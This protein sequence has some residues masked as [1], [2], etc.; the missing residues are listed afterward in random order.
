VI[1]K[2]LTKAH[3]LASCHLVLFQAPLTG[4]L[5]APNDRKITRRHS[6]HKSTRSVEDKGER[7]FI[8]G[9]RWRLPR[10][11]TRAEIDDRITRL[12]ELW[13]DHEQFTLAQVL[14]APELMCGLPEQLLADN[15]Q[16]F[17]RRS[18]GIG[19]ASAASQAESSDR[20]W[21]PFGS[22]GRKGEILAHQGA[23][24]WSP[25]ALWIA[26]QIKLG[27]RPLPLPP[28][29]E[30][31][32]SLT[33]EG[34]VDYRFEPLAHRLAGPP[35][36]RLSSTDQLTWQDALQL[37]NR[38]TGA[39]PSVAWSLPAHHMEEAARAQEQI[40]RKAIVTAAHVRSQQ[41]PEKLPLIPGSFHEALREYRKKRTADFT[42]GG[43]FDG[44]GHHML[45]L[46]ENFENRQP[47]VPLAMLDFSRCQA[48]YDFWR[49]RPVNLRTNQ[50]LSLKHCSS[51]I[52]ELTRFFK[53]LHT[54]SQFAWRWPSDFDL[55]D[56]KVKRLPSDRRSIQ[57]I[58]L[59]TFA[60][61]HLAL[62]YKHA[63]PAQ[64][65][66]LVWCLNC[67]H[68]AAEMGRVEWEDLFLSQP[69]PW[70]SEGLKI[71]SS[72][73]DSWCGLLRPKT[74]VVGWWWLWPETVHLV[75][76]WKSHLEQRLR[77]AVNPSER[78]LLTDKGMPLY[79]DTSRNA[80]SSFQSEWMR[81][82]SRVA[83]AEGEGSVP[84]LP[85]G[86]LRDQFS[87]WLGS[88]Q[89]R[90]VIASVALAHGIPHKGDKLL[91]KHYSN[92]PWAH[93]FAAQKDFRDLM[94]PLFD[95]VPDPLVVGE[96]VARDLDRES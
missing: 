27:V 78:I 39:Y 95:A 51:H 77:R 81:L 65:L 73:E 42:K 57:S 36:C 2:T 24:D 48:I 9:K 47:N 61:E 72:G 49:N 25:L 28:W 31:T 50:P 93:L 46:I 29:S 63:L 92:R 89:N 19:G 67:S 1:H 32:A 60:V 62:L 80:Q 53:W 26:E 86:T 38:L 91:Y 20:T 4:P 66:K 13:K 17:L 8:Q 45:G 41:P 43:V 87:N 5:S 10:G 15:A 69:H 6:R 16:W 56:T 83:K 22:A 68:G 37:L 90:A 70:T 11:L 3:L 44:S 74:D 34:R 12:R 35:E 85:F 71:A 84:R 55:L 21:P 88:D 75:R 23:A 7:F 76:W 59:K 58:D 18:T 54:T 96:A 64:R 79:R 30:L 33:R 82:H 40:A 94:Q 52:G 14:I